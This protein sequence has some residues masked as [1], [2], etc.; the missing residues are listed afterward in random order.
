[1]GC[2]W[3]INVAKC[4]LLPQRKVEVLYVLCL[5]RREVYSVTW[6]AFYLLLREHT[7]ALRLGMCSFSVA[8]VTVGVRLGVPSPVL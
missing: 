2:H 3:F 5:S 1:M 8:C 4:V 6:L 7:A